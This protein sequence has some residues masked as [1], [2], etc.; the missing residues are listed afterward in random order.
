MSH[1]PFQMTAQCHAGRHC[2]PGC[3][4]WWQHPRLLRESNVASWKTPM[5]G[6]SNWNIT[7][8]KGVFSST[9]FLITGGHHWVQATISLEY[10]NFGCLTVEKLI[11]QIDWFK[12]VRYN[13]DVYPRLNSGVPETIH[14]HIW[15]SWLLPQST[16][17]PERVPDFDPLWGVDKRPGWGE[18]V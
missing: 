16:Y 17:L 12:H 18:P 6:G 1:F 7:Y 13:P 5:N 8:I 3:C 15:S 14:H 2:R 10:H 9:P 4:R 11:T